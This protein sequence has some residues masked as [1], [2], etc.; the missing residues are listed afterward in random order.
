MK[1]INH[2]KNNYTYDGSNSGSVM[3]GTLYMSKKEW[4]RVVKYLGGQYKKAVKN[5]DTY[6]RDGLGHALSW[7][8]PKHSGE[9]SFCIGVTATEL[10]FKHYNL[11]RYKRQNYQIIIK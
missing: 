8:I 6:I 3:N 5:S 4:N 7:N 1:A 10:I 2:Q 9:K 11:P